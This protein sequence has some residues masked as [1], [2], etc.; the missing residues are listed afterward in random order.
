M[1]LST[2]KPS[3]RIAPMLVD[4]KEDEQK[5]KWT[6]YEDPDEKFLRELNEATV[7]NMSRFRFAMHA[8]IKGRRNLWSVAEIIFDT[9]TDMGNKLAGLACK[10]I[11]A[12]I[13]QLC[14]VK[15]HRYDEKLDEALAKLCLLL[16]DDE[17]AYLRA[18]DGMTLKELRAQ[19]LSALADLGYPSLKL[20][21]SAKATL[22]LFRD[23]QRGQ[24][25]KAVYSGLARVRQANDAL[26]ALED[27]DVPEAAVGVFR[28]LMNACADA[29]DARAMKSVGDTAEAKKANKDKALAIEKQIVQDLLK[30]HEDGK[31]APLRAREAQ[32]AMKIASVFDDVLKLKAKL[33][34]LDAV[35][36]TYRLSFSAAARMYV[37]DEPGT[38]L[39]ISQLHTNILAALTHD[40]TGEFILPTWDL[41]RKT[42]KAGLAEPLCV[43][44][45]EPDCEHGFSPLC[46]KGL[47]HH[48]P[49]EKCDC[50]EEEKEQEELTVDDDDGKEDEEEEEVQEDSSSSSDEEEDSDNEENGPDDLD[51]LIEESKE[52]AVDDEE[53]DII[54]NLR[55]MKR[56]K[57]DAAGVSVPLSPE[58]SP[59]D[60]E[61]KRKPTARAR[62]AAAAAA[63]VPMPVDDK[64][65]D[66]TGDD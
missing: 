50:K 33:D 12:I 46:P 29:G 48:G 59:C 52:P 54:T 53:D 23:V 65:I 47:K 25:F 18:D 15:T 3:K 14:A 62:A 17:P 10:Y 32:V 4:P 38:T 44:R 60:A 19:V 34:E 56:Q 40:E 5:K 42:C 63:P 20:V 13:K 35:V 58:A 24:P 41:L 8:F 31:L 49:K 22:K 27:G 26:N 64:V 45:C 57:L 55:P 7:L 61:P 16:K 66:L 11:L 39:M 30:F 2:L 51:P 28:T 43:G 21:A 37:R 9:N 1:S 6:P 36:E